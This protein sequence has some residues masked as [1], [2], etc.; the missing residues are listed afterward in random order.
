MKAVLIASALAATLVATLAS[1]AAQAGTLWVRV[2]DR[3]GEPVAGAAVIVQTT[4]SPGVS[5]PLP[6]VEILQQDMKFMPAVAVV[7][8]GTVVRFTNRDSFDH[9]VRGTGGA[10]FE[11]RIAG[12][13][14]APQG[15][16]RKDP[17]MAAQ[18]VLQAGAGP[19]QV[20]CYLHSR[21]AGNI[22]I[23]ESPYFGVSDADGRARIDVPDGAITVRAWH[24]QQL[25]EQPPMQSQVVAGTQGLDVPLN[26]T[27]RK[28][29]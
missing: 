5:K 27:P 7:T 25:L 3:A 22:Y 4:A 19:V 1:S 15:S 17:K 18:V 26:F 8:P 9:H 13:D 14:A 24:P 11:Y 16:P 23:S 28:R 10:T 29:R 12:T 6:P 20:G 21:M 2:L